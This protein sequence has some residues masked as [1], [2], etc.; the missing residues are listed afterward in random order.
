MMKLTFLVMVSLTTLILMSAC[1]SPVQTQTKVDLDQAVSENMKAKALVDWDSA[2][3]HPQILFADWNQALI[4]GKIESADVCKSLLEM[5]SNDL[6]LFENEIREEENSALLQECRAQLMKKLD[7]YWEKVAPKQKS[8]TQAIEFGAGGEHPQFKFAENIQK[9]NLENGYFA[10]SGDTQNNEVILTFDDGPHLNFTPV[11]LAALEEVDA[12]AIFFEV[13]K[14]VRRY[15]EIVR[16]VAS[17]GHSIGGHSMSHLCLPFSDLCKR[18]NRGQVLTVSEAIQDIRSSMAEIFKVLG[19]VDPFFRF[20]YGASSREL[21]AFLRDNQMGEFYWSVDSNDWRAKDQA[22]KDWTPD[23]MIDS[24]MSQ[25]NE[26]KRGMVLMHDIQRKTTIAL[27][28]LLR[29]LYQDGFSPVLLVPEN[30]NE[31]RD[32]TSE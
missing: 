9:R 12:K 22:G 10:V 14:N 29:R 5:N 31:K 11:I 2:P 1:T 28:E 6:T 25:L 21:K 4:K 16:K 26:K 24:V 18:T 30:E 15:P 32:P 27:P 23:R 19:W 13:G 17:S 8:Q 7:D 20:P 3:H